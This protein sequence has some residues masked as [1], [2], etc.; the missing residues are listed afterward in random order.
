MRT[1]RLVFDPQ[2]Y[3]GNSETV[4]ATDRFDAADS[5]P[6]EYLLDVLDRLIMR[7]NIA[8]IGQSE[9]RVLRTHPAIVKAV[10]GNNGDKGAATRQ[11][12]AELLEI[13]DILVGRARVNYAKPGQP[14]QLKPCWRGGMALIYRD[15]A[16]AKVAG[17]V[18]GSNV[19]F[20]FTAQYGTRV[21]GAKD[22]ASI[23][24]RGG[25]RVRVG[26][27]VKEVIC[28]PQLGFFLKDV[29]T[30]AA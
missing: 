24:L 6:V 11:Q 27:S 22:D 16:A 26:E 10:H 8:V 3:A 25:R 7:P 1:S 23:G 18:E 20:G 9:W 21:A 28:A 15:A 19:T 30:P 13:E 12:V 17:V 2:S 29:I 5:D 4:A 14:G